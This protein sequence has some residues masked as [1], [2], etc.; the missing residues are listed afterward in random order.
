MNEKKRKRDAEIQEVL[1]AFRMVAVELINRVQNYSEKG[2]PTFYQMHPFDAEKYLKE[3][4]VE[5]TALITMINDA[6]KNV[7]TSYS[8][9]VPYIVSE[10]SERE[11]TVHYFVRTKNLAME[12]RKK[13]QKQDEETVEKVEKVEQEAQDEQEAHH[14]DAPEDE[15]DEQEQLQ[16]ALIASLRE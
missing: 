13:R 3:L 9:S 5:I 4:H 15:M 2:V 14:L 1:G 8:Y 6:M 12:S 11:D 7:S 16:R 10:W